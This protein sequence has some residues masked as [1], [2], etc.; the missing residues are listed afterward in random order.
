MFTTDAL[1]DEEFAH[2]DATPTFLD[3]RDSLSD[4]KIE[5]HR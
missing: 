1:E 2:Y 5:D 3:L 4:R